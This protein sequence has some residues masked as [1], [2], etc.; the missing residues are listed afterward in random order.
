VIKRLL[1]IF[2]TVFLVGLLS[3][4]LIAFAGSSRI[5][6]SR[7]DDDRWSIYDRD[8][9][10]KG[11]IVRDR[12]RPGEFKL[13]DKEGK[14]SGRIYRNSDDSLTIETKEE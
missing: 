12:F 6:R 1:V 11:H 9:R 14:R 5:R 10:R 2:V 8:N 13:F 3:T 7:V 4:Y